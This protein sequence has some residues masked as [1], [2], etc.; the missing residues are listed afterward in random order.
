MNCQFCGAENEGTIAWKVEREV[1]AICGDCWYY[2]MKY[3]RGHQKT[4]NDLVKER[5]EASK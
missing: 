5:E 2:E 3:Q 1:I 4:I